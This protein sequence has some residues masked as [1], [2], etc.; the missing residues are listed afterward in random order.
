MY[1]TVEKDKLSGRIVKSKPIILCSIGLN[2]AKG[3][4]KNEAKSKT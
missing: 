2:T 4:F 1:C 3:S